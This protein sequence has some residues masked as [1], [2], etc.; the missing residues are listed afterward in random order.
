MVTVTLKTTSILFN[1]GCLICFYSSQ[2]DLNTNPLYQVEDII[3]QT[4]AA[5]SWCSLQGC[6]YQIHNP[7]VYHHNRN[8]NRVTEDAVQYWKV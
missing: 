7:S 1:L 2:G 4:R 6:C 3:Y 8:S 5:F